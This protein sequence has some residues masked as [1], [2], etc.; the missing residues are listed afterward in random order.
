MTD[1]IQIDKILSGVGGLF[2]THLF[3]VAPL[4]TFMMFH[5]DM[6][7]YKLIDGFATSVKMKKAC[8]HTHWSN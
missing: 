3:R 7:T 1:D 2:V 5:H 4:P 8:H 6:H